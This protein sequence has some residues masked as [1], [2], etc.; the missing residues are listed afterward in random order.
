MTPNQ[1]ADI[2]LR[3]FPDARHWSAQEFHALI[4]KPISVLCTDG[5]AFVLGQVVVDEAEV[6]TL[7]TDPDHQ[8]KGH[9][10]RALL[11]FIQN[12]QS[13]GAT[14]V[15]LEVSEHNLAAQALYH[16]AGFHQIAR[17][18]GYYQSSDGTRQ[19]ALIYEKLL[20]T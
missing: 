16:S 17:R 12:V 14:R 9:A 15:F 1:L 8:R 20:T 3:A 18:S 10:Q 5:P 4:E 19:D 2:H 13:R 7:A 11:T 6:L